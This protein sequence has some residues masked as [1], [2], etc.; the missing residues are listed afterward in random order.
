MSALA[1]DGVPLNHFYAAYTARPAELPGVETVR[2]GLKRCRTELM[3]LRAAPPAQDYTGPSFRGA[4]CGADGRAVLG[5]A[6]NGARLQF[7]QP[8]D[9]TNA[10]WFGREERLGVAARGARIALRRVRGDDPGAKD[11]NGTR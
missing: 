9:G 5:P 7:L 4:R 3:A 2:K 10:Q 6:L 1:D 11:F 8:R